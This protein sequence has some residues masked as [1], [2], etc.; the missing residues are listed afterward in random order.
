LGLLAG[1][2]V[3]AFDPEVVVIG[4]GL[5]ERMGDVFVKRIRKVARAQFLQ[6]HNADQVQ[7]VPSLLG[8]YSGA[9][10]SCVL[11]RQSVAERTPTLTPV[12]GKALRV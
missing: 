8:A 7:I 6:Q 2:L 5:A 11:V 4:G 12:D 10:G 1:N 3:N 9:L